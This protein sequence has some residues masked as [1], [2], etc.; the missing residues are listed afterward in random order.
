MNKGRQPGFKPE[1]KV[2]FPNG[3]MESSLYAAGITKG[4]SKGK[5]TIIARSIDRAVW[6]LALG[7]A[8][9]E[10]TALRY[11]KKTLGG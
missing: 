11:I 9:N 4:F 3:D 7:L 10:K 6:E 2:T 1:K 8:V 5:A